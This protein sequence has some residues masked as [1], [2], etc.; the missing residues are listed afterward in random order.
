M[1]QVRDLVD[2]R[3]TLLST[4]VHAEA[5]HAEDVATKLA[6]QTSE[7]IAAMLATVEA[8]FEEQRKQQAELSHAVARCHEEVSTLAR[9]ASLDAAQQGLR[10]QVERL[11]DDLST[12]V[13]NVSDRL[14]P[15]K[16][17]TDVGDAVVASRV[18]IL[19]VLG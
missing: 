11:R 13:A 16:L 9:Q 12:Q 14:L 5:K 10:A 4:K 15:P 17:V 2:E 1:E 6:A 18:Q 7:Q 3:T 8:R 19:D